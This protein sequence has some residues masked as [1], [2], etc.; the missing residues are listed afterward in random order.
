MNLDQIAIGEVLGVHT[1][2]GPNFYV[3]TDEGLDGPFLDRECKER[4]PEL[5]MPRVK[6][7][8]GL[9]ETHHDTGLRRRGKAITMSDGKGYRTNQNGVL[10]RLTPK[11]IPKKQRGKEKNS[12][13]ST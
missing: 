8:N 6:V 13:R 12:G 3:K 1:A 2:S 7:E 9:A 5:S 10:L 4:V 11:R